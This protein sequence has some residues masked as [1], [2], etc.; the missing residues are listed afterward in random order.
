MK[1]HD[2]CEAE[3]PRERMLAYG[4]SSLSN[5]ELMAIILRTGVPGKSAIEISQ[6]LFKECGGS[7]VT[8]FGTSLRKLCEYEAIGV[9]KATAILAVAELGRRFMG[10]S[11]MV[12]KVP[13]LTA[14]S[15]YE[16]LLPKFKGI[17]HEECWVMFLNSSSYVTGF[18]LVS[19]GGLVS[20]TLEARGVVRLALDNDAS[21]I[22]LAH[23]HPG[24]D[25]RPS[26]ADIAS[27]E[28][29]KEAAN[30][31]GVALYDH[32]ILCDDSFYSFSDER[33]YMI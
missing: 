16:C 32:I 19:K 15:A 23:N 18:S 22:I 24:L 28:K 10:E 17:D 20:T 6:T 3:R 12:R 13:V 30:A 26:K 11:S 5:S 14:R 31:C 33:V 29:I 2:L 7:L 27:T 9:G 21:A 8:L 4:P 1:I 25:P